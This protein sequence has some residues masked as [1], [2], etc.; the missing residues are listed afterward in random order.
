[1]NSSFNK[2]VLTLLVLIAA[3]LGVLVI[4]GAL[5]MEALSDSLL[6]L[7]GAALI[8]IVTAVVVNLINK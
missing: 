1:M 5:S 4:F 8:A 7:A 3:F 6:R 2:I